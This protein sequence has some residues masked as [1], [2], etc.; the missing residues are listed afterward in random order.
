MAFVMATVTPEK[1]RISG[2]KS[3]MTLS[4]TDT[5]HAQA[6]VRPAEWLTE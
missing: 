4:V 1:K 2:E 3:L 6:V 5:E